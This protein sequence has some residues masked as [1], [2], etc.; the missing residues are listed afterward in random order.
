MSDNEDYDSDVEETQHQEQLRIDL[1]ELYT[2]EASYHS[3]YVF[4][5]FNSLRP[6]LLSECGLYEFTQ[7]FRYIVLNDYSI[8]IFSCCKDQKR[9]C[10][11]LCEYETD[12]KANYTLLKKCV[13]G[14]VDFDRFVEFCVKYSSL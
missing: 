6:A 8:D 1:L 10:D 5:D 2:N 11:F 7:L 12:I 3:F 14:S 13:K 4:K 9:V